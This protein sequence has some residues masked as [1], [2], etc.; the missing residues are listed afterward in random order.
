MHPDSISIQEDVVRSVEDY[1]PEFM[2]SIDSHGYP[3]NPPDVLGPHGSK[4]PL[5]AKATQTG[6]C[7]KTCPYIGSSCCPNAGCPFTS[8]QKSQS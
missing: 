7:L 6:D 3:P 2:N 5:R 1:A 8:V 4:M